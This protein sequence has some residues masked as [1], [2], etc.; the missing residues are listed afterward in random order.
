MVSLDPT[1]HPIGRQVL[2]VN[3]KFETSAAW[4]FTGMP[5]KDGIYTIG[6]VV[7][8]SDRNP[9][10]VI[11]AVHLTEFPPLKSAPSNCGFASGISA[12]WKTSKC[13]M[14]SNPGPPPCVK[15][16]K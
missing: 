15:I 3:D 2:C 12:C 5:V 6:A 16:K 14:P 11:L 4:P 8:I 10:E 7:W 13:R 1:P 9:E